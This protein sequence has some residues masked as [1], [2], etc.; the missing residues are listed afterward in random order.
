MRLK[1]NYDSYH[2]EPQACLSVC[3]FMALCMSWFLREL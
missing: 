3:T 1:L 2:F